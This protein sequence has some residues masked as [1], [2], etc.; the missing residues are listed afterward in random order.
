[1]SS[2]QKS[3]RSRRRRKRFWF[4]LKSKLSNA[5][6]QVGNWILAP[7]KLL[8]LPFRAAELFHERGLNLESSSRRK[9]RKRQHAI[10]N[11]LGLPIRI[12]LIPLSLY[13]LA[14]RRRKLKELLYFVP[15]VAFAIFFGF[16]WY[17][18]AF[19]FAG[20]HNKYLARTRQAVDENKLH[21]AKM[22]FA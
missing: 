19:R 5:L 7:I 18:N 22:Y 1:M 8:F 14:Q 9:K 13:R 4:D 21:L 11:F 3:G 15:A 2:S 6:Q 10:L 17:Q 12:L 16:V 20:M